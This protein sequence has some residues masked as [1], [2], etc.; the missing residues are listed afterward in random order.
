MLAWGGSLRSRRR[1]AVLLWGCWILLGSPVAALE[2][3]PSPVSTAPPAT[4]QATSQATA[5]VDAA[6]VSPAARLQVRFAPEADYG[7]FVYLAEDGRIQGLSVDLL[8]RLLPALGWELVMLPP[9][10][11]AENLAAARR[12]EADLLSSLR[13]TPERAQYLAFSRPYVE[14]PAVLVRRAEEAVGAVAGAADGASGRVGHPRADHLAAYVGRPVAVGAGYAVEAHVRARHPGVL[15]QAV[16]DD[17]RALVLLRSGAVAAAVMDVASARF[18]MRR[19]GGE[20]L[21]VGSPIGF[22]YPL[23]FAWPR[24]RPDIGEALER[25]LAALPLAERDAVMQRWMSADLTRVDGNARRWWLGFGLT[26]LVIGSVGWIRLR[27]RRR[28]PLPDSG[29]SGSFGRRR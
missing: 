24:D 10:P 25:A 7:P 22:D 3:G 21:V 1:G 6:R 9:R 19:D 2:S 4:L 11:L 20:A 26:A 28:R 23:S 17:A 16:A 14:V 12:G 18:L 8:Q 5:R 15:W 27:M 29:S 13:P